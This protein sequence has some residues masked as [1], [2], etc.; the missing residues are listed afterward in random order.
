MMKIESCQLEKYN[1]LMAEK[2]KTVGKEDRIIHGFMVYQCKCCHNIYIMWLEKGLED[3]TDDQKTGKHKPVPFSFICPCCGGATQH[4][5]E[6]YTKFIRSITASLNT[7]ELFLQEKYDCE[8]EYLYDDANGESNII[9]R[10]QRRHG[11]YG[12]D[13]YKRPRSNKKLYQY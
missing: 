6:E 7:A 12:K 8:L 5:E 13:G 2:N 10:E 3:P 1:K 4:A 9:N 11:V